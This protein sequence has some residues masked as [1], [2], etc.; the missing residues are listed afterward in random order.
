MVLLLVDMVIQASLILGAQ[1]MRIVMVKATLRSILV[2]VYI[3]TRTQANRHTYGYDTCYTYTN[4]QGDT[5]V[6]THE[7]GTYMYV[8]TTFGSNAHIPRSHLHICFCFS[9]SSWVSAPSSSLS[10]VLSAGF[11]NQ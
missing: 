7:Y 1:D 11:V 8:H 9:R 3:R 4:M 10:F 2:S 5:R 6:G